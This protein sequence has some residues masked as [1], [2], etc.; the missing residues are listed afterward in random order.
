[1]F[2]L[3]WAYFCPMVAYGS[4][5]PSSWELTLIPVTNYTSVEVPHISGNYCDDHIGVRVSN[6]K[7]LVSQNFLEHAI[8]KN[9]QKR[10]KSSQKHFFIWQYL[11]FY[12]SQIKLYKCF[13]KFCLVCQNILSKP[14]PHRYHLTFWEKINIIKFCD[15]HPSWSYRQNNELIVRKNDHQ[16]RYYQAIFH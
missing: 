11:T 10:E 1:M 14:K 3:R 8:C 12:Q 6:I 7:V 13:C 4:N 9:A 2:E 15:E 5:Q 16:R